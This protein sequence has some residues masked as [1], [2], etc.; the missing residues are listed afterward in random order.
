MKGC[1]LTM[2]IRHLPPPPLNAYINAYYYCDAPVLYPREQ[3]FPAPWLALL[4]NF[5][6]PYI[7]YEAGQVNPC[8][9]C[10]DSWW[11]GLRTT[12]HIVQ[13]TAPIRFMLVHFKPGG[14]A[15]FMRIPL[16]DLHHRFVPSEAL[17]GSFAQEIC[18]RL[19]VTPTVSAKFALLDRLLLTRLAKAPRGYAVV[20]QAIDHIV[21]AQGSISI[22]RL[23]DQLGLSQK[24]LITQ[25][26]QLVGG[27][28]KEI[29]RIIRFDHIVHKT[30]T[31]HPVDWTDIAYQFGYTDQAHFSND[32][33]SFTGHNPT[34]YW[35]LRRHV[36]AEHP[37]HATL[38]KLP[39]LR[40]APKESACQF[41][42]DDLDDDPTPAL[43]LARSYEIHPGEDLL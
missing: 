5:G 6:G 30:N 11:V 33:A 19:A 38:R 25:F 21:Q 17:W 1:W 22:R 39:V 10:T 27:T 14:A 31:V 8:A 13:W 36:F 34:S 3:I 15:P 32:F 12:Y 16:D 29:A 4:I 28:P 23:S 37:N 40:V 2:N 41:R 24:H 20:Q 18:E 42:I 9:N 43:P 26:K 35:R 7:A